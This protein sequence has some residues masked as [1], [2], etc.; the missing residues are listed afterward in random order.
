MAQKKPDKYIII[1]TAE[2]ETINLKKQSPSES[3]YYV[4]LIQASSEPSSN[5][6]VSEHVWTWTPT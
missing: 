5:P 2:I 4:R 6:V 1:Q 3:I